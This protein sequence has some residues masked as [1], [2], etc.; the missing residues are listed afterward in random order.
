MYESVLMLIIVLKSTGKEINMENRANTGNREIR[1][2]RE[3]RECR[4][5]ENREH[6]KHG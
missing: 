3:Q 5:V 2:N 6:C 4:V 1:K